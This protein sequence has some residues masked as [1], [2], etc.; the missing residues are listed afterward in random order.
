MK[1]FMKLEKNSVHIWIDQHGNM[2][3]KYEKFEV[4]ECI[5]VEIW[6]EKSLEKSTHLSGFYVCLSKFTFF[7]FV[8]I[9]LKMFQFY[10]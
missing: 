3:G 5:S 6:R 8:I 2:I 10:Q 1:L 9:F 7:V 4:Y